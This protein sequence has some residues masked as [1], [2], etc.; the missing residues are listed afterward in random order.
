MDLKKTK[1]LVLLGCLG[2]ILVFEGCAWSYTLDQWANAIK[3]AENSHK[4]PYGIMA[5]YRHTTPRQACI[6]TVRHNYKKWLKLT[7][8]TGL[9][10]PFL[11]YL[12]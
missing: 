9:K 3:H 11:G 2:L 8:E 12:A 1:I 7:Q 10:Q 4:H 6:N 5:R